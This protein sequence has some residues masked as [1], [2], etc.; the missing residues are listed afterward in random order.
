M[1]DALLAVNSARKGIAFKLSKAK[2]EVP[3]LKAQNEESLAEANRLSRKIE[4]LTSDLHASKSLEAKK[5]DEVNS[6]KD[7][8]KAL[9]QKVSTLEECLQLE[10]G[11]S[12]MKT[13]E[14]LSIVARLED[15]IAAAESD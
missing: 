5:S 4:S 8:V 10:K 12:I 2:D 14:Q 11:K 13:K 3:Q 15:E 7:A 6:M 1:K 9:S